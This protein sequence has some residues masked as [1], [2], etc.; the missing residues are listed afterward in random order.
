MYLVSLSISAILSY[1]AFPIFNWEIYKTFRKVQY[2]IRNKKKI[3]KKE[4]IKE[5]NNQIVTAINEKIQKDP[6]LARRSKLKKIEK[7]K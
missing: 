1:F 4:K 2:Y 6:K 7:S 3:D 5:I